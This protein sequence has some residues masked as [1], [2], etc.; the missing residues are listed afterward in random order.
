MRV[1]EKAIWGQAQV[2]QDAPR[3]LSADQYTRGIRPRREC[4]LLSLNAFLIIL[5]A[6]GKTKQYFLSLAK[7]FISSHTPHKEARPK[8]VLCVSPSDSHKGKVNC[9]LYLFC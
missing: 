2:F 4:L 3:V 7:D 1:S 9:Q 5:E 8:T 6:V